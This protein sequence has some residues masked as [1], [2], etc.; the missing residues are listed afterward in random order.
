[1]WAEVKNLLPDE[2]IAYRPGRNT[3]DHLYSLT[4]LRELSTANGRPLHSGFID[5][6]KAFPSVDR[7]RLLNK[8]SEY[9]VSEK[10][11]CI[12]TRLYSND[13]FSILLDG[14]ASERIYRVHT[15]VHEGSPLSP[16]LFILFIAGLIKHLES[17]GVNRHGVQ[18]TNGRLLCCIL[19]ADDVLLVAQSP[20]GLQLL[21]DETCVFFSDMGMTVNPD[22]SDIVVFGARSGYARTFD[23][24]GA[25]KNLRDEAKY[26]GVIFQRGGNWKCQQDATVTRCRMARGRSEIICK[27]LGIQKVEQMVQVFDM[28]VSSVARYSLGAWGPTAGNLRRIDDVFVDFIKR[29]YHLPP[30]TS[31]SDILMNFGRR[32]SSCDSKF[33]AAVQVA[34]GLVNSDSVWGNV[35][36]SV[37]NR[38][39]IP[40]VRAV[41]THL[42]QMGLLADLLNSLT[43]FLGERKEIGLAFT[44]FCFERHLNITNGRSSDYFRVNRP[45]GIFPVVFNSP[46]FKVR[47]LLTLLLSCWRWAYD[48]RN[49]PQYCQQCDSLVNSH[50]LL[51]HCVKT[52][53]LRERFL[54]RTGT[55][56]S[57][58][59]LQSTEYE[60]D[61]LDLCNDLV[62]TVTNSP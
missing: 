45:F 38:G 8:L 4:L 26:L 7:Q 19:Y 40:W 39:D 36:H 52:Q 21:I 9:G 42:K 54:A 16:L 1:M 14:R 3:T 35:L 23:I 33:L 30:R 32:C 24:A 10:F 31:R 17:R 34:R 13:T 51:F 44:R 25:P 6:K 27:T 20:E 15:G 62:K 50:H 29:Q 47:S 48:A 49:Y 57:F 41:K 58:E 18:L 56:F 55:C 53:H 2:Q 37:W 5:L 28:F 12:L 11:L 60:D 46:V 22:K 43:N 61:I 59:S